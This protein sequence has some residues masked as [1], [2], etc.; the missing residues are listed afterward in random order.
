MRLTD[1]HPKLRRINFDATSLNDVVDLDDPSHTK[2][3]LGYLELG[4]ACLYALGSTQGCRPAY[5]SI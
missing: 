1:A 3:S 2:V 4:D 5:R